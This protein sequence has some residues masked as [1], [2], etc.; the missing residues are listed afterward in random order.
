M[1]MPGAGSVSRARRS[2]TAF[3]TVFFLGIGL[4]LSG[5]DVRGQGGQPKFRR[6]D[7]RVPGQ[8]VVVL[9]NAAAGARGRASTADI[10]AKS[11]VGTYGGTLRHVFRSALNGFAVR[12]TEAAAVALS[13]DPRVAFVEEDGQGTFAGDGGGQVNPPSWGLDR[14]DQRNLPLNL[15]YDY[16][17]TGAGVNVYVIDDGIRTTHTTFGNRARTCKE[18]VTGGM[19]VHGTHVAGIIGGT[20]YGVAKLASLCSVQVVAG[21]AFQ[22]SD[23]I[24]GVN[25]VTANH[26]KPAIA[27][28]SLTFPASTALDDAVR[29]S[30]AAGVTYVVAAGNS[31]AVAGD[32]TGGRP[33]SPQRVS[34]AL[35][36]AGS[37]LDTAVTPSRD[38][39]LSV[40]NFGPLIDVFAPGEGILS[41][42]YDTDTSSMLS[43]GTSQAAPHVTGVG[44]RYL[45][46]YPT[47]APATVI[48]AIKSAASPVVQ[49]TPTRPN[50]NTTNL[51]LYSSFI[52]PSASVTFQTAG[53]N[54]PEG[55]TP[56]NLVVSLSAAEPQ[57]VKVDY[58]VSGGTATGSGVDYTLAAGTLAFNPAETKKTIALAIAGDVLDEAN[59][60][61]QVTLSNPVNAGLGATTIHTYTI[62]DDD[63][64]PALS[65]DDVAVAEG[66][67]GATN[68]A[69]TVR[70]SGPSG[71]VVSV[72]YTTAD[73]SAAAPADYA[74]RSGVL[75]F[76]PGQIAATIVVPVNG[77][78]AL[79]PDE[80]FFMDLRTPV[81]ATVVRSR[82]VATIIDDE[83]RPYLYIGDARVREG[84]AGTVNA[85]FDVVLSEA[86]PQTITVKYA[87]ADGTAVAPADY[88]AASGVLTFAPG[89][90]WRPVTV[91]VNG[92]KKSEPLERFFVG[93]SD[94]AN[95]IIAVDRAAGIIA[96]DD[97]AE[98]NADGRADLLWRDPSTGF[99]YL[100]MMNGA[101][102]GSQGFL[103]G[104]GSR[105][106]TIEGVGDFDGDGTRDIF[107]RSPYGAT[108][109]WLVEG[110]VIRDSG[111]TG[112]MSAEWKIQGLADVNGDGKTDALWRHADGSTQWWL[113]NGLASHVV[114]GSLEAT[115]NWH[116]RG[117]GDFDGN[118]TSDVFWQNDDGTARVWWMD[119]WGITNA[120]DY[121][122]PAGW[123]VGGFGDVDGDG[124]TDVIWND[125][126]WLRVWL[127]SGSAPAGPYF[128]N[129][130]VQPQV[131]SGVGSGWQIAGVAD[132]NGDG[133]ADI[134]LRGGGY[135]IAML[136]D[137]WIGDEVFW[138]QPGSA[139]LGPGP[140]VRSEPGWEISGLGDFDGNGTTDLLWQHTSGSL[141]I[142]LMNAGSDPGPSRWG[143][144]GS[145]SP[146]VIVDP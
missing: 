97:V 9:T 136:M 46:R 6:V 142:N 107:W 50:P 28:V 119:D 18:V 45:Q 30:I 47:V 68:A 108:G 43:S 27:N 81:N 82:G 31:N 105:D 133:R 40:S 91:L 145:L 60:T 5:P 141:Y 22:T 72:A 11:L 3:A 56:A 32:C 74:S 104:W 110:G 52:P 135:T 66:A 48:A 83:P 37:A 38:V 95:A 14:I 138:A 80:A 64:S 61:V 137:Q 118:G 131:L 92:E 1:A 51:L 116:V 34:E 121:A 19:K 7:R 99:L 67:A 130:A 134:L 25:W 24:A 98:F 86:S 122:V 100:W 17:N 69:F 85:V 63:P 58:R 120:A 101:Y 123:Q 114:V 132:V 96:P 44:A 126:S 127:S 113:M 35:L 39:R 42:G 71:Q 109:F 16:G 59:E 128:V 54:G 106:L 94:A 124:T 77:D 140:Q 36:V 23:A 70:M 57:V 62:N 129:L 21:A 4:V 8:F 125:G 75:A 144:P 93:L 13:Q 20:A 117:F 53:S 115:T 102:P 55:A 79:E 139:P 112:T 65:I 84:D 143:Q 111:S 15:R 29:N 49:S 12:M 87:T 146:W 88:A 10:V 33:C 41:A 76:N 89:E 78:T 73:G 90:T 103:A 26:V 2:W